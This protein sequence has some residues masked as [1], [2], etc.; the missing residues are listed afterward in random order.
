MRSTKKTE[1]NKVSFMKKVRVK[2]VW[3]GVI[4]PPTSSEDS[5]EEGEN[6]PRANLR[7]KSKSPP[8]K[9]WAESC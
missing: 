7:R 2:E 5:G 8:R 6:R 3:E 9:D 4:A 1:K